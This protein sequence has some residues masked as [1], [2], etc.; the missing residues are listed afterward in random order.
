MLYTSSKKIKRFLNINFSDKK[1]KNYMIDRNV[2]NFKDLKTMKI[3]DVANLNDE[4]SLG[5]KNV[6]KIERFSVTKKI[7]KIIFIR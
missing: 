3:L 4:V 6:V 7:E 1:S 5:H 2:F